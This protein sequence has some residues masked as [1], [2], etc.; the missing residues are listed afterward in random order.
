MTSLAAGATPD[1][2][3]ANDNQSHCSRGGRELS[4]MCGQNDRFIGCIA[5]SERAHQM[6]GIESTERC[7]KRFTSTPHNRPREVDHLTLLKQSK[8]SGSTRRDFSLG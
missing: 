3:N 4:V 6:N 7:G 8:N 1:L 2:S 5:P